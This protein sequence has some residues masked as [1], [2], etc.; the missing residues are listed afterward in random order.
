M[1]LSEIENKILRALRWKRI[2]VEELDE[3]FPESQ[4]SRSRLIAEGLISFNGS[5]YQITLAGR[6][7][8]MDVCTNENSRKPE[9]IAMNQ[10]AEIVRNAPQW[11]PSKIEFKERVV[12]NKTVAESKPRTLQILEF[13]EKNQPCTSRD[14][15][16]AFDF[17][18][19]ASYI[20]L[21]IVNNRVTL[22]SKGGNKSL[23]SLASGQTA[24]S[25]YGLG[26]K[27]KGRRAKEVE[28]LDTTQVE[29]IEEVPVFLTTET[30]ALAIKSLDA[31]YQDESVPETEL[32]DEEPVK[33]VL[34]I[35]GKLVSDPLF[36]YTSA[37]TLMIIID[38]VV[39]QLDPA[40]TT[41]L[42]EFYRGT[43]VN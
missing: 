15:R 20:K 33:E 31:V 10:T 19:P 16:N 35:N 22:I 38:G 13:I 25:I 42:R 32:V 1:H 17:E 24:E 30:E 12:M 36:A 39:I 43:A 40:A 6:K 4:L 23:Y 2:S 26:L 28:V 18:A 27:N 37:K 5:Y 41:R 14:L 7:H 34:A 11:Q 9:T 21:H 3:V 8:C 29:K